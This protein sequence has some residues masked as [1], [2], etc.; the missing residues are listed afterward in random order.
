MT[1]FPL[2]LAQYREAYASGALTP[3]QAVREVYRRIAAHGRIGYVSVR[4]GRHAMLRHGTTFERVAADFATATL[5]GDPPRPPVD[6]ILLD[7]P[8]SATGIFG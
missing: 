5:L 2:T 7:A 8:C 1:D 3:A 4:G 6:A